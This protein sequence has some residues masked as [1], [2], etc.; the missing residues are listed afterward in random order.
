MRQT[1]VIFKNTIYFLSLKKRVKIV[2]Q[3]FNYEKKGVS[4]VL[5]PPEDLPPKPIKITSSIMKMKGGKTSQ[6]AAWL[7]I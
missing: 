1:I 7:L 5:E 3:C 4:L 6:G 2:L